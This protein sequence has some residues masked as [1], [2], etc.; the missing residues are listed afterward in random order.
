MEIRHHGD[1]GNV[2]AGEDGKATLT[3]T[4]N[5][6]MLYGENAI[7]GRSVVCHAGIDDLGQVLLLQVLD[8]PRLA[9]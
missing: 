5:L 7:I 1:L 4:D 3:A 6:L 8:A 2:E 9:G